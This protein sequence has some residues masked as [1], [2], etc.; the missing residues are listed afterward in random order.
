[1]IIYAVAHQV[2]TVKH[3]TVPPGWRWAVYR[4]DRFDDASECFG[5]GWAP[6]EG[7]AVFIAGQ[8]AYIAAKA[9]ALCG[10]GAE[11]VTHTLDYDPIMSGADLISIG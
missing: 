7:A 4:S 10:S 8:A 11:V 1:M 3:P 6:E 5:A 2:D 9:L